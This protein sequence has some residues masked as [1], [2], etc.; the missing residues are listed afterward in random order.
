MALTARSRFDTSSVA[1]PVR[2]N[3]SDGSPGWHVTPHEAP[4]GLVVHSAV[5]GHTSRTGGLAFLIEYV[6]I[7]TVTIVIAWVIRAVYDYR[8]EKQQR[9]GKYVLHRSRRIR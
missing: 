3:T 6:V 8:Q 5:D 1:G 4:V 7:K 9:G 2:P